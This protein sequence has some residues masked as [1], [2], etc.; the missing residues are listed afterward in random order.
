MKITDC[1][2]PF[3]FPQIIIF[4]RCLSYQD[5]STEQAQSRE[6]SAELQRLRQ[7]LQKAEAELKTTSDS[8]NQSQERIESLSQ[9]LKK[10]ESL[11]QLEKRRGS[12]DMDAASN[13]NSDSSNKS[14]VCQTHTQETSHLDQSPAAGKG[15]DLSVTHDY[16]SG[17]AERQL[18]ERLIE[19]EKEVC[20]CV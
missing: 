8:L 20:I 4:E 13:S 5:L 16:A 1:L 9:S 15:H 6:L 7:K 14:H 3:Y 17:E 12:A 18:S 10:S 11:L 19:L 2:P